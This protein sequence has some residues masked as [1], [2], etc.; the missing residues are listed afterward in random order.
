[1]G[2]FLFVEIKIFFKVHNYLS[3]WQVK[4]KIFSKQIEI[5]SIFFLTFW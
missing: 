4:T 5:F 3:I 1:M 2:D